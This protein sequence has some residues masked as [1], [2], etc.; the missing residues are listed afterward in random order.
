VWQ[1][2]SKSD[3]FSL[4]YANFNDLQDGS[5]RHLEFSKFYSLWH[6]SAIT[7]LFCLPVQNVTEIGLLSYGQKTILKMAAI[8]HLEF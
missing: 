7:M 5:M 3:D 8:C 2:A 6:Y 4:R 1:T